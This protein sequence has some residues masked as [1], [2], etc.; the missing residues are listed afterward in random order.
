MTS[1]L[2]YFPKED[3]R[4]YIFSEKSLMLQMQGKGTHF[5][6]A[7]DKYIEDSW[8]QRNLV[9]IIKDLNARIEKLEAKAE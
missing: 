6:P 1:K 3:G 4:P 8:A 9:A 5:F 7:D 2:K